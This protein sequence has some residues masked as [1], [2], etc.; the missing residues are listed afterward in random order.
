LK[1][2]KKHFVQLVQKPHSNVYVS[3]YVLPQSCEMPLGIAFDNDAKKIWYVSTKKGVLG[4]YDL[5]KD[6]V[7][8]EYVIP[9]WKSRENPLAYSQVW[10]VQVDRKGSGDFWF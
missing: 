9:G 7:D 6:K 10:D 4:S 8:Q 5:R 3:E 1:I 2:F